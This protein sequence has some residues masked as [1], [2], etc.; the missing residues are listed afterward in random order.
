MN[1]IL[2][3][4]NDA[5]VQTEIETNEKIIQDYKVMKHQG[6]N[7]SQMIF[8]LSFNLI[9][10]TVFIRDFYKLSDKRIWILLGV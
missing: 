9:I 1:Y 10:K 3:Q 2:K 5:G 7:I 8:V 6:C 4:F